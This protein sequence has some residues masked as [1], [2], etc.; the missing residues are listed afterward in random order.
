MVAHRFRGD[1]ITSP[2]VAK[3]LISP[4]QSFFLSKATSFVLNLAIFASAF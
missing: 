4:F 1:Y 3:G 2:I